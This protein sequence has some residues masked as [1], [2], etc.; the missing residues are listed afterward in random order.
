VDQSPRY[1][2]AAEW[3]IDGGVKEWACKSWS[4]LPRREGV[5]EDYGVLE[6]GNRHLITENGW[7]HLQENRKLIVKDGV[8]KPI[9]A[10]LTVNT[11]DRIDEKECA[12]AVDLWKKDGPAWR[13]VRG[14]WR[15]L[16]ASRSSMKFRSEK[17]GGMY[18]WM[19]L[20]MLVEEQTT[21]PVDEAKFRA[22]VKAAIEEFLL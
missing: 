16:M 15:E 5:R 18:L 7:I 3:K 9:A 21:T 22:K 8:V 4:P 13:V 1:D 11:Y 12:P 20:F 19:R 14:M 10:E 17:L 2:C 6:R